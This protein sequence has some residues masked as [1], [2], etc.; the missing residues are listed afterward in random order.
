LFH[1]RKSFSER[2]FATGSLIVFFA[3]GN[4]MYFYGRS[5]EHNIINVAAI[6]ALLLFLFF[7][8]IIG[9]IP[10]DPLIDI[11]RRHGAQLKTNM[12]YVIVLTLVWFVVLLAGFYYSGRMNSRIATQFERLFSMSFIPM[13]LYPPMD[14]IELARKLTN[15]D[16]HVIF[17]DFQNDFIYGFFGHYK[18]EGYYYPCVAWVL[19]DEM[20]KFIQSMLDKDYYIIVGSSTRAHNPQLIPLQYDMIKQEED[21]TVLKKN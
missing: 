4:S 21:L 7:D 13:R 6:L 20:Y 15:N 10:H 8:I 9:R 2:Y 17:F 16:P 3:V 12:R 11:I 18:P 19:N 1:F 5:H 14:K